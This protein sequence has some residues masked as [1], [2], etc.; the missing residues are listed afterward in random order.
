MRILLVWMAIGGAALGQTAQFSHR[1]HLAA[2]LDCVVCHAAALTSTR[3]DDNLLPARAVCLQCHKTAEIGASMVTR[4]ARFDH[5]LHL[6]L[7]NV[8]PIIAAAIDKKTYLTAAGV[9]LRA[10]LSTQN[11]C[12]ACHRGLEV[13][14]RPDRSG[15]PQMADCLVCHGQIDP[16]YSCEFCHA[17]DAKLTPASHTPDFLDTHTSGKLSFDKTSCAVCHGRKFHCLGCH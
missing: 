7:G 13:S 11:L 10:Q 1:M 15:L 14:E 5:Q 8:A 12:E 3:P 17:N 4:L 2:K 6:K 16:P 9:E